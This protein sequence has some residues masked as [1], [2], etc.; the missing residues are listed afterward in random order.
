VETTSIYSHEC[1]YGVGVGICDRGPRLEQV[2]PDGIGGTLVRALY[3]I[4]NQYAMEMRV[5]RVHDG[6]LMF[7]TIVDPDQR[8]TMIGDH[9][10]AF[11]TGDDVRAVDVTNWS[12]KWTISNTGLES[13]T[14]LPEGKAVMLNV[15]TGQMIE[16]DAM[17]AAIS[18]AALGSDFV[19]QIAL[20][21][22]TSAQSG[23]LTART[24]L[25]LADAATSFTFLDQ[26]GT[27]AN[28]PRRTGFDNRHDSLDDAALT[29]LDFLLPLSQNAGLEMGGW[30]CH[31]ANG[32]FRWG[33]IQIG[34]PISLPFDHQADCAASQPVAF[35]H[36]HW[37]SYGS[38]VTPPGFSSET[39]YDSCAGQTCTGSD[40]KLADQYKQFVFYL[41]STYGHVRWQ[42]LV[43][44]AA[45]DN[46][47]HY[48]PATRK[49]LR[50]IA[51]W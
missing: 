5:M 48:Q 51:P 25:P 40:L 16:F 28:T 22:W 6:Q 20:G 31:E 30:I 8:I 34:T 27:R 39:E 26:G 14:A 50:M 36:T 13:V 47:H 9:G 44:T 1:T 42:G 41:K 15:A 3:S 32:K 33:R 46:V 38:A 12:V 23:Q 45:K 10:T 49:W 7:S 17:G 2:L 4:G 24:S 29:Y 18:S 43:G 19:D 11:V 35:N 37:Q 21:L